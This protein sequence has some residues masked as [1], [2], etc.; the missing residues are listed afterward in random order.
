MLQPLRSLQQQRGF[1]QR[2]KDDD[3]CGDYGNAVHNNDDGNDDGSDDGNAGNKD[4]RTFIICLVLAMM[5]TLIMMVVIDAY[6]L[7]KTIQTPNSRYLPRTEYEAPGTK[8]RV[9]NTG[10]G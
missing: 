3:S 4:Y 1:V 8:Y 7:T 5:A 9:P 2:S 10:R 6:R